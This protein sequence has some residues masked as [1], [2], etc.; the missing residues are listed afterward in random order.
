MRI[1]ETIFSINGLSFQYFIEVDLDNEC[2]WDRSDAHGTVRHVN[3]RNNGYRSFKAP[4]ERV[5]H[6]DGYDIWLYDF[7]GA[8]KKAKAQGWV[9]DGVKPDM[10]PGKALEL[11]VNEDMKHLRGWLASEWHYVGVT[12]KLLDVNGNPVEGPEESRWGIESY[13]TECIQAE[14]QQMAM[15][16]AESIGDKTE[17]V[18]VIKI[19]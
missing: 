10:H 1:H 13:A 11:A 15:D 16:I 9:A 8:M 6:V 17:I 3:T 18:K 4:G 7:A 2:P 5:I 19:R 12:V 14:I